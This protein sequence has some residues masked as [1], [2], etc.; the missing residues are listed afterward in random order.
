MKK[1]RKTCEICGTNVPHLHGHHII[2]R[3]DVRCTNDSG[4]MCEICPNCHTLIHCGEIIIIGRYFTTEGL[5]TM[6]FKKGEDPPLEK[7][8]WLVKDNPFVITLR[9]KDE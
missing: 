6:W 5:Q 1:R 3:A 8:F 4:N 9:G 2:P 7:E